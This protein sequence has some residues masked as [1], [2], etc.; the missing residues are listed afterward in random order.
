MPP[1]PHRLPADIRYGVDDNPPP[2][3][4]WVQALQHLALVAINFIFVLLVVDHAGA[5]PQVR[6]GALSMAMLM[7]ALGTALQAYRVGPVGSGY[8]L[9]AVASSIY[10][11]PAL[12]AVDLGGLPLL[13]GML[14]FAGATQVLLSRLLPRL[15][16]FFPPEIAGLVILLV[17]LTLAVIGLR[18]LLGL[19]GSPP[20]T[21]LEAAIGLATLALMVAL[22]VWGRG[23]LGL[24]AALFGML[25]GCA[26]A[27]AFGVLPAVPQVHQGWSMLLAWPQWGSAGISFNMGLALPFA[28]TALASALKAMG[29][30]AL[31]QRVNDAAWV[32]PDM[33]NV[34]R[35]LA[36]DG[37]TTMV[38]ALLGSPLGSNPGSSNVGLAVATGVTSRRVAGCTALLLAAVAFVPLAAWVFLGLPRVVAGAVLLFTACFIMSNGMEMIVS[39]LLDARKSLVIGLALAAG[40]GAEV[41]PEAARHAPSWLVPVLSSSLVCGTLLALLLNGLFRLGVRQAATLQL[42]TAAYRP[43]AVYQFME[44]Q[45]ALWGARRDVIAR[46][47]LALDHLLEAVVSHCEPQG[48]LELKVTFDEF[49]LTAEL[50]HTGLSLDVPATRPTPDEI[51]DSPDGVRR[52]SG[53][54][55]GK[56]ADGARAHQRGGRQVTELRFEH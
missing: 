5:S 46:A 23:I 2:L 43:E 50:N 28:L 52:L 35:G 47:T 9:P 53:Y 20:V 37:A 25:A 54:L 1:N 45:G 8:L 16:P 18:S 40:V 19:R 38:G 49:R 48:P 51:V 14:L 13:A 17:G 33:A 4:T 55:V 10:L 7:C 56:G 15:R 36:A 26:L 31:S 6:A 32:R 27:A 39:R 41:F 44:H 24:G 29:S 11:G 22:Q 34:S 42:D 12:M 3:T 21:G 30:V